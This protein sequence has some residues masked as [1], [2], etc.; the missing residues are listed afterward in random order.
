MELLLVPFLVL[1]CIWSW[2]SRPWDMGIG[3]PWYWLSAFP[4]FAA[5]IAAV[6]ILVYHATK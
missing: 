3:H 2:E 5:P 6:A 1:V 4:C